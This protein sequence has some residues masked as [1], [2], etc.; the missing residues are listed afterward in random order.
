MSTTRALAG[1]PAFGSGDSE[2]ARAFLQDRL[3]MFAGW[4]FLLGFGFWLVNL[5][6]GLQS[7]SGDHGLAGWHPSIWWH[8]GAAAC[9]G[10]TWLVLR[11]GP[12][13][14]AVLRSIEAAALIGACVGYA[15]MGA[16]LADVGP[17][18]EFNPGSGAFAGML[19]CTHVVLARA[20]TVPSTAA[21]TAVLSGLA[22]AALTIT[23]LGG[24]STVGSGV[25][26]RAVVLMVTTAAWGAV[27]T[28]IATLG[29][30]IIFGLRREAAL[31]QRLGQYTLEQPLG[32]G[33]MGIVY[34]ARHAMLRR[35]TAIKLL[36]PDRAGE[37]AI[38]RFERE[39]QLTA[40]LTHPNTVA[41]YDYGRT[42]AGV[43]YYA[44]EYLPGFDLDELVQRHGPQPPGRVIHI[45]RQACGALAEAHAAGLIHRDVKPAN[46]LLTSRGGA[47]DVL[48]LLDFGL[49]KQLDISGV[50]ATQTSTATLAGTPLYISPEAVSSEALVDARSDLYSLGGVGYYLLS[51]HTVFESTSFI[52]L[53]A[54]HL[55]TP[56]SP[57]SVHR[58]VPA[59]LEAVILRCLAKAPGERFASADDLSLALEQCAAAGDWTQS[60]ATRWW[61]EHGAG[62]GHPAVAA[63]VGRPH[64][65][66]IAVEVQQR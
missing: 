30:Q 14:T 32:E 12:R 63:T 13:S 50:D 6:L 51:G 49:V 19:A 45:L 18:S 41:I 42:P 56:P 26:S 46:M 62:V 3:S 23:S 17:A 57:L 9:S 21:R 64:A 55:H 28:T 53:C 40:Q 29:S 47:P 1:A 2:S 52:E 10:L 37:A 39:V 44:M 43:F 31:A 61:A 5:S 35:P 59:D 54:H 25:P 16:S 15:M 11:L 24:L 34:L 36:P 66:T 20:V 27:T 4:S 33:A 65:R 7:P 48:K 60:V 58:A 8:A 38:Q 22:L